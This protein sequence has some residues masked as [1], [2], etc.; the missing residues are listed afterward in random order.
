M[1]TSIVELLRTSESERDLDW[2]ITMLGFLVIVTYWPDLTLWLP[3]VL[4]M[5]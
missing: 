3:R 2:L 1:T 4:G 5:H